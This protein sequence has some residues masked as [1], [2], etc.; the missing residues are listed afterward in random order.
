M[1]PR[2]GRVHKLAGNDGAFDL[3]LQL[4]GPSDRTRH[5]C[6][7]R[8]QDQLGA[9]GCCQLATLDG[10]GLGHD[11]DHVVPALRRNHGKA[12]TGVTARGFDDG[13][14]GLERSVGLGCVDHGAGNSVLD[15]AARI[16]RLALA[17]Q[18][19]ATVNKSREVNER[20]GAN[21]VLDLGC[22][23]HKEPP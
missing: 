22:V 6:S 18:R 23:R 4:V 20:S 1:S 3:F 16:C 2:V 14:A 19:G 5:S 13:P 12:H 17:E 10:H 15:R 11:Q 21:K 8:G 9:I 7:A